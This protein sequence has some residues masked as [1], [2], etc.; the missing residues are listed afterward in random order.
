M[1]FDPDL[2]ADDSEKVIQDTIKRAADLG[3][4]LESKAFTLGY[5]DWDLKRCI[6]AIL[7]E[8]LDF[9]FVNIKE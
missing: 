3:V 9:A 7:P 5:E 2:I 1:L 8:H 4:T 6:R